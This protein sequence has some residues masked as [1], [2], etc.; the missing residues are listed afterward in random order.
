MKIHFNQVSNSVLKITKDKRTE[1]F[2]FGDDNAYPSLIE[3]LVSV[4]VTAGNCVDLVSKAIYGG[5]FGEDGDIVVNSQEQSLNEVLRIASREYAKQNNVYLAIGYN[6]KG[7]V[8]S[9]SVVPT[10]EARLGKDDDRGYSGK[11][12][13][14]DNWDKQIMNRIQSSKFT[15]VDRFSR[16]KEILFSQIKKAGRIEEY[17]GQLLHIK[18]DTTY[19][20]SLSDLNPVLSDALIE[21]NSQTFRVNGSLNG[22][23]NTKLLVTPPFKDKDS[24]DDFKKTLKSAQGA[25]NS[26]STIVLE[27]NEESEDVSKQVYLA[28]LSSEYNDELF[29]Y[30]DTQAEK[31]ICKAF[32]VPLG[33]VNPSDNSLF[34]NSGEYLKEMKIQLYESREE[35]RDQLEETFGYLMKNFKTPVENLSIINPYEENEEELDAKNVNKEAQAKLR[36]SVGG[37]TALISL[38]QEVKAGTLDEENAVAMIKNIYGFTDKKAREMVGGIEEETKEETNE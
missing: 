33:L 20:Y 14:Y 34:G 12:V 38:A 21:S 29:Q 2:N 30:S 25:E 8:V 17:N 1:V 24:L 3:A 18:K 36:G 11:Y 15:L 35:Q 9:I 32:V 16:N 28:D 23:L 6:L 22:F 13:I 27:T 4:S 10:V 37:V 5:S 31:N 7:E 26:G 19:I